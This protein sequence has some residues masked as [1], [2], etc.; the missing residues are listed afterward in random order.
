MQIIEVPINFVY[1]SEWICPAVLWEVRVLAPFETQTITIHETLY[2]L[3][4]QII[5]L[6]FLII[7]LFIFLVIGLL[8]FIFVRSQG[9]LLN[10]S[11]SFIVILSNGII[12]SH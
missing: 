6:L 1:R 8:Y 2:F 10:R 11:E 9:R 4:L 3:E 12:Y 5:F 7:F